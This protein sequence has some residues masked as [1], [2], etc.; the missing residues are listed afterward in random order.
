M[1][2]TPHLMSQRLR[3]WLKWR[4]QPL[5]LHCSPPMHSSFVWTSSHWITSNQV[6]TRDAP[7]RGQAQVATNSTAVASVT[8]I[9]KPSASNHSQMSS[10]T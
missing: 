7:A 10:A 8:Y 4:A 2:I 9:T 3:D 5:Q 6:P 1:M